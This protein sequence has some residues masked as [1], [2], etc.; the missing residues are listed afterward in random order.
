MH[1]NNKS[2]YDLANNFRKHIFNIEQKIYDSVNREKALACLCTSR[3]FGATDNHSQAALRLNRSENSKNIIFSYLNINSIRNKFD[4]VKVAL[5]NYV[6]IFI[7][8]EAKINESF[9]TPQFVIY[10][11]NKAT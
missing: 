9:P 2:T 10:D 3:T 1:L 7:A 5:V 4:N 6:D 8:P 11:Y